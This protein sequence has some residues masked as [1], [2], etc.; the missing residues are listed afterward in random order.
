MS[1]PTPL[2]TSEYYDSYWAEVGARQTPVLLPHV[3]ELLERLVNPSDESLDVGCGQGGPGAWLAE[4]VAT[5]EGVDVSEEALQVARTAGLAVRRIDDAR[6]LP[7]PD[8]RFDLVVCLEVLE[9][10]LEPQ[11]AAA[12]MLRVLRPSG[13][14]IATVPNVAYWRRRADLAVFGRWN[15]FGDEQSVLRPWRDPHVRFFSRAALDRMLCEVGFE[16]VTTA[17]H[18]GSWMLD[19]P[20]VRR[21]MRRPIPGPV[22]RRLVEAAPSVFAHNLHAVAV[23]PRRTSPA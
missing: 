14:L 11:V 18:A 19:V 2:R 4:R 5:Y 12:E 10:L 15:P 20:G 22:Y 6:E 16:P 17:G 21:L 23:K 13:R 9:H 7:Y 1:E 3:R 8:D